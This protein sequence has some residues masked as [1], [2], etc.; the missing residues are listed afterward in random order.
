MNSSQYRRGFSET[1]KRKTRCTC[2][3]VNITFLLCRNMVK[4][5]KFILDLEIL[6][7]NIKLQL[8]CGLQTCWEDVS[9]S[10]NDGVSLGH[11]S[12]AGL[13]QANQSDA[14]RWSDPSFL[15]CDVLQLCRICCSKHWEALGCNQAGEKNS[16]N[17]LSKQNVIRRFVEDRSDGKCFMGKVAEVY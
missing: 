7:W 11:D 14:S 17:V 3:D 2:Q 6:K 5:L 4:T 15:R 13:P 10:G 16:S 8:L 1:V 12:C 9:R